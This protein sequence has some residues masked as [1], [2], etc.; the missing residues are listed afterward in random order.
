MILFILK[1][2]SILLIVLFTLFS[3]RWLAENFNA[4]LYIRQ[5]QNHSKML[6]ECQQK[7][8]RQKIEQDVND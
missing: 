1:V 7:K 3:V 4:W 2:I 8:E 6:K 5:C